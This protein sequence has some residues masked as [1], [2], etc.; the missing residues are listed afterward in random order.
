LLPVFVLSVLD[1]P[2]NEDTLFSSQDIFL[3]KTDIQDGYAPGGC[4]C[5]LGPAVKELKTTPLT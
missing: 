4:P 5:R 2:R 3:L 1:F